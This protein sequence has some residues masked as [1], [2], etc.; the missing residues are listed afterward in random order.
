MRMKNLFQE[1]QHVPAGADV[2]S[3]C[4]CGAAPVSA[5]GVCGRSALLR[6]RVCELVVRARMPL[7]KE[8]DDCY[9]DKYW[10]C[11]QTEQIGTAR[12]NVHLH[13]LEW[14]M[15]MHPEAG[16]VVDVGCGAGAFLA[17][18]REREWRGVGVDPSPSA[19]AY[20]NAM[21]LEAYV[22]S[23][24]SSL[25]ESE[26]VDAVTFI[27]VLDHLRDPFGALH[28]AWRVLRRGGLLY[29]RVPNGA[30]RSRLIVPLSFLGFGSLP[31]VFHLYGFSYAAFR[32]HLPRLGFAIEAMRTAPPSQGD[33]YS[34]GNGS[35]GAVFRRFLKKADQSLYAVLA[36][37]GLDR[38]PLGPSIEVMAVKVS[39]P[40]RPAR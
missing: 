21:G 23:W 36:W 5:M 32:F 12:D 3:L 15:Q 22:R 13:A 25:L 17:R 7:Q 27:N 40:V 28:E 24:P 19:V 33:A 34:V 30:L 6:C 9:R 29:I 39:S 8:L 4:L 2:P 10:S 18:C 16:T 14:L 38:L 20:A 26:T 11:F 37:S 31:V 1:A 35:G